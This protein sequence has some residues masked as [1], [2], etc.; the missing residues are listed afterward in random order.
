MRC[1]ILPVH[2]LSSCHS[3]RIFCKP[4]VVIDMSPSLYTYPN[5]EAF[6]VEHTRYGPMSL[7]DAKAV[8]KVLNNGIEGTVHDNE[9]FYEKEYTKVHK[10][11]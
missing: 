4:Y 1:H 8:A 6:S 10:V 7:E 5:G 2:A 3:P 9:T 11:K